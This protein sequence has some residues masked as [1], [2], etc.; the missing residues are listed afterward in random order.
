MLNKQK[1]H[2]TE[3]ILRAAPV[4]PVMVIE[5]VKQAVPFYNKPHLVLIV[6][7]LLVEL[8]Q[9]HVQSGRRRHNV[10]HV[11]GYVSALLL[12]HFDLLGVSVEDF[13]IRRI[14]RDLF[15]ILPALVVDSDAV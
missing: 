2:R 7:V 1:Q 6:P 12:Q 9:H 10:D 13:L 14:G 15:E 4:V 11:G 5:D 8:I 3:Q